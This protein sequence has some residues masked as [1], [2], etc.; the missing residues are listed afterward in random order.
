M[1]IFFVVPCA[2]TGTRFCSAR[3]KQ[4]EPIR[5]DLPLMIASL[6]SIRDALPHHATVVLV[7]ST[8][9]LGT[10]S[11]LL[12][13]HGMQEFIH[14]V[15][16]D[17]NSRHDSILQGMLYAQAQ[18]GPISP[19]EWYVCIQDAA[20]P[21]TDPTTIL[22]LTTACMT[23]GGAVMTRP[24]SFTMM[25][26]TTDGFMESSVPRDMLVESHCPQMFRFERLFGALKSMCPRERT[27][28]TDLADA[29]LQVGGRVKLVQA[30]KH[31][32]KVTYVRDMITARQMWPGARSLLPLEWNHLVGQSFIDRAML[33]STYTDETPTQS[34]HVVLARHDRQ[35]LS[36]HVKRGGTFICVQFSP[37]TDIQIQSNRDKSRGI[38]RHMVLISNKTELSAL[39]QYLVFSV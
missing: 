20:R 23:Y 29:F 32:Q 12:S 21:Y 30:G 25:Q 22:E 38:R 24:S 11:T 17:L 37:G 36:S 19:T 8:S 3:L 39:V 16:N 14:V 35:S 2:G 28:G 33:V 6:Q 26:T 9:E 13:E 15:G 10:V 27:M 18:F 5:R 34:Y 4:Y 1:H 31:G 7:V